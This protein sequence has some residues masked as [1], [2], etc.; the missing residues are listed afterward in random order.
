MIKM[1]T[2]DMRQVGIGI[3]L[4]KALVDAKAGFE[5]VSTQDIADVVVVVGIENLKLVYN[6]KQFFCVVPF[7]PNMG[8]EPPSTNVYKASS[9]ANVTSGHEASVL[10]R[11]FEE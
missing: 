4:V 3:I 2:Q 8:F 9:I 10:R 11:S 5:L 6:E 7:P 1:F